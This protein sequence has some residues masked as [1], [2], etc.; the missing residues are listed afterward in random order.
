MSDSSY[1]SNRDISSFED[2]L[3]FSTSPC[4][5]NQIEMAVS[6]IIIHE[7]MLKIKYDLVIKDIIIFGLKKQNLR[8]KIGYQVYMALINGE[9]KIVDDY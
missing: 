2:N 7:N 3:L 5:F 9:S 6:E 1:I 4:V 8:Y